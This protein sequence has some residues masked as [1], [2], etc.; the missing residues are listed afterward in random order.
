MIT[1]ERLVDKYIFDAEMTTNK[2]IFLTGPRQ[3]G[4]TTFAKMWLESIGSEDTYFNW[5]DPSVMM[6]YKKNP[7]Y[8]RNVIDEKIKNKPV[9]LVFD[10][11]HKHTAWRD[12]LKGLYD[13]NRERMRLLVTGSARLGFVRKSGD[14][15]VGRYFSYQMFPLGL[16]EV[17]GDFSYLLQDERPFTDGEFLTRLAREADTKAAIEGLEQL[18][19]FGGF[20]EPFLKGSDRFH[21]RWQNDYKALLTK[22]EVRDFSRIQ[23]IRGLETMVEIL[24]TKVGSNLSIPSLVDVLNVSHKTIKNWIEVL[25]GVYLVFTISAW[26]RNIKRS[27]IKEKKLYFFEWSL[28]FDSGSRFENFLAVNL[29][30]M[31]VKFTEIGLGNFE[32]FYIRDKEKR[33][34]DFALVKDNE[35]VAL[36][37]AKESDSSISKPGKFYSKKMNIPLFQIVH[38]A[39]KVEAFPGNCFV[40]PAS[41]FLMLTG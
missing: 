29:L 2:M 22:E 1:M 12:I 14:S 3:V 20:P 41:N 40:I 19:K 31:A 17:V 33:E 30:R 16:P 10:E 36:F 6:E 11:I 18:L 5:D 34:V 39:K 7:L 35:P 13:T 25:N 32:I 37:E 28:L 9:P 4:K 23:D 38:K 26:H 27:I 8:F 21:R 24:P 15:L